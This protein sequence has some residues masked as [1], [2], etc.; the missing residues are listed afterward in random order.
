MGFFTLV[1]ARGGRLSE[2]AQ[3]WGHLGN[4]WIWLTPETWYPGGGNNNKKDQQQGNKDEA[5]EIRCKKEEKG[6]VKSV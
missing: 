6:F 4:E 5:D 2:V 3:T 1:F